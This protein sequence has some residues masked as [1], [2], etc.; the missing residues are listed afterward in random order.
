MLLPDW[1]S[2]NIT[3]YAAFALTVVSMGLGE[4]SG[5][6]TMKYSKFRPEKGIDS[7][8][9]MFFLYFVPFLAVLGFSLTYLTTASLVQSIVLVAVGGHFAKRSLEALFLHKYSGPMDLFTTLMIGSFYTLVAASISFLNR[10]PLPVMDGLAWLGAG[11]FV[12]GLSGNFYYHK[13]LAHLRGNTKKYVIPH[14][15]WFEWVACPHY[16]FEILAWLGIA[17]LSRH[18]FTWM[19]L[20]GM[21]GYLLAR[22]FKTLA[23]YRQKFPKFPKNRKALIPFLL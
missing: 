3:L 10:W 23:W 19:A 1:N 11:L 2:L 13:R 5:L 22:S 7:R 6:M 17:L 18:L 4:F 21:S 20:L 15:G 9:G 12:V 14:G 8:T 16:L